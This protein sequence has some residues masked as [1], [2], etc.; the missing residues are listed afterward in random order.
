MENSETFLKQKIEFLHAELEQFKKKELD[1]SKL[2]NS[3]MQLLG[4]ND[5]NLLSVQI[6]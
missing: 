1:Y 3:L 6:M 5:E 2:N 4:K